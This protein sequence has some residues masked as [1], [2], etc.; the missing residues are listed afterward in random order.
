[1]KKQAIVI[2][3]FCLLFVYAQGQRSILFK[4]KYLPDRTYEST[5]SMTSNIEMN[6]ENLSKEEIDKMKDKGLTMPIIATTSTLSDLSIIT[7]KVNGNNLFPIIFKYNNVTNKVTLSGKEVPT[8]QSPLVGHAMYGKI[9]QAGDMHLDSISGALRDTSLRAESLNDFNNMTSELKLP[10]KT[11][12]VGDTLF[13]EIP[14]N[15]PIGG[16]DTKFIVKAS[17]R[18]VSIKKGMANFDI[19]QTVQFNMNNTDT[20]SAF[21]GEGS[22]N[23]KMVYSI[24]ENFVKSIDRDIL[25]DYQMKY[26]GKKIKATARINSSSFFSVK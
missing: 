7:G 22:G 15:M 16:N 18:L 9:T 20:T 4:V 6:I 23:G 25:F 11:V 3:A 26:K 19:D 13:L 1:M 17:Y 24:K 21:M 12:K 10:E 5:V 8:E 2:G 14:Y